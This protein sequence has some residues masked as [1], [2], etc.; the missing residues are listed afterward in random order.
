MAGLVLG[1]AHTMVTPPA[2]AAAVPDAKSSLW[3]PP[4]SRRWTW[5]S[6]SPG[7]RGSV[8]TGSPRPWGTRD[9]PAARGN[10]SSPRSTLGAP[11]ARLWVPPR[12][13]SAPSGPTVAP[14][15]PTRQADEFL[16]RHAVHVYLQRGGCPDLP[17][18]LG[19]SSRESQDPAKGAGAQQQG[20]EEDVCLS[21]TPKTTLPCYPQ[22]DFPTPTPSLLHHLRPRP[23]APQPTSTKSLVHLMSM[24]SGTE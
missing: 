4:G 5:T 15:P 20:Q 17:Q 2:S 6:I 21:C 24:M 10:V 12:L 11:T 9:A 14:V 7:E 1:M 23:L 18:R 3:V 13:R 16:G 19:E 22:P 8:S